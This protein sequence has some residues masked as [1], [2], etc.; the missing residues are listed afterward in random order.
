MPA[1]RRTYLF[2]R[3]VDFVPYL[4]SLAAVGGLTWA[5]LPYA[6]VRGSVAVALAFL[7][8]LFWRKHGARLEPRSVG[9]LLRGLGRYPWSL[10]LRLLDGWAISAQLA[11]GF[12]VALGVEAGVRHVAGPDS[13]WLTPFPALWCFAVVF[14]ALTAYRT[15]VLLA[16]LRKAR[17]VRQV[18]EGSSW[19]RELKGLSTWAH[20]VH[21]WVTGE[22]ATLAFFLPSLL[23]WQLT[24]PTCVRE[25]VLLALGAGAILASARGLDT[26]AE[27]PAS[28]S[29]RV[30]VALVVPS[31]KA[32]EREGGLTHGADHASRFGFTLFHGHH[33]DAVPC[34]LVGGPGVGLLE[35]FDNGLLYLPYLGSATVSLL[36]FGAYAVIDMLFHQYV[37]GVFPYTRAV[38]SFQVHHVAHH[39]FSL[40]PVS[41][42]ARYGFDVG[43]GYRP[44]NAVT[45]WFL[46]TAKAHEPVPVDVS[47]RFL[48]LTLAE[49]MVVTPEEVARIDAHAR[50]AVA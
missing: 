40:R 48:R 35:A 37:P 21:A 39:F 17:H 19:A 7:A 4:V 14:G 30:A 18:L 43:A 28:R 42:N 15:V 9:L 38:L 11:L 16:H 32:A 49:P 12:A 22:L 6:W 45:R 1:A 47:D 10:A 20:L 41:V 50:G 25:L 36:A 13:L 44:D 31:G 29:L 8:A 5:A 24:E 23:F 46:E 2:Y 3:D 27:V 26:R 33:H 34:A